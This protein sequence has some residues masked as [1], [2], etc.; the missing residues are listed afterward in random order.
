MQL[1]NKNGTK[2]FNFDTCFNQSSSQ[3][4][5]FEEVEKLVQ[6]VID[7]YNICIFAYG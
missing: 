7:G 1:E 4:Q 3:E 6:S 5:I 2:K